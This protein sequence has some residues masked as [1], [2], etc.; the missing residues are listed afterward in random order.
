ML[1]I[2][3]ASD[4]IKVPVPVAFRPHGLYTFPTS[5]LIY[6]SRGKLSDITVEDL[7]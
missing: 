3:R 6:R 5:R 4:I 1:S 2:S 7:V